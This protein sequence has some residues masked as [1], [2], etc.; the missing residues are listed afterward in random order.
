MKRVQAIIR[1]DKLE[2]VQHKLAEAGFIGLMV[3]DV[4]G[5]GSETEQS[6]E[7]RG[8][9]FAMTVKH[10]LLIDLL[11]DDEEVASVVAVV[12]A[13]AGTGMPGDGAIFVM[14][15]GAVYPINAD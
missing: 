13:S 8:V 11:V 1:P 6:G 14:D 2:P 15:V 9:P 3:H 7:Y 4:R 10:K 12:R 5:H